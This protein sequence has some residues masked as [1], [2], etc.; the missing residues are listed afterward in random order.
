ML[1]GFILGQW[2]FI[3]DSQKNVFVQ[4]C[5]QILYLIITIL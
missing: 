1:G 2:N 5:Q 3:I 4:K